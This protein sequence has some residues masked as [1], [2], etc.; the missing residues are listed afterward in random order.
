MN[1][2]LRGLVD[3]IQESARLLGH[4]QARKE[5]GNYT[6]ADSRFE[7]AMYQAIA[8]DKAR[9]ELSVAQGQGFVPEGWKL[10]PLEPTE[11]MLVAGNYGSTLNLNWHS[12]IERYKMQIAAAPAQPD[13]VE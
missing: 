4:V 7:V 8:A 10:V 6:E 12:T 9:I 13:G 5:A 1:A 11:K 3:S 2:D